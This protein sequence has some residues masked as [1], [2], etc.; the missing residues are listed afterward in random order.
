[1]VKAKYQ[2]VLDLGEKLKIQ[3]GDVSE[4]NGTL[5]IKGTAGTQYEKNQ[6]WDKIKEIGGESPSDIV[7][8]IDVADSS[9]F[10]RHTVK[11]G[12]SLSKIAKHYYGDPMKYKAIFEANTNILKNPDVIHPDQELIIPNL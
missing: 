12:E 11:S 6:L 4:D 9:V 10:H 3:N 2:D 7:A 1:M 8:D 5:K